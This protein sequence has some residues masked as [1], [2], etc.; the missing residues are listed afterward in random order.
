MS[1]KTPTPHFK[2]DDQGLKDD[3]RKR[4]IAYAIS[5]YD[6]MNIRYEEKDKRQ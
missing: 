5:L 3:Y 1:G 6:A 2:P 4:Q